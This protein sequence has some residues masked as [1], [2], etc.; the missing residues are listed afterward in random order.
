[1]TRYEYD[2]INGLTRQVVAREA[3]TREEARNIKRKLDN[4]EPRITH[5]IIQRRYELKES[6]SIR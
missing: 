1:M 6:V 3:S 2:V 4:E 5:R